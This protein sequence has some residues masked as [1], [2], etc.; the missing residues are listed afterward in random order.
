M[1]IRGGFYIYSAFSLR[2]CVS[3]APKIPIIYD[4]HPLRRAGRAFGGRNEKKAFSIYKKVFHDKKAD[5]ELFKTDNYILFALRYYLLSLKPY[6][7]FYGKKTDKELFKTGNIFYFA[8]RYFLLPL[9]AISI[10]S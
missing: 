5:T 4:P 3:C 6:Q 10:F 2:C 7:L 1:K 9:K 8:L